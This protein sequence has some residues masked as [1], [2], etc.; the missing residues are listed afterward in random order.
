MNCP[1][2]SEAIHGMAKFCPKCGLPLKDD[3][4]LMGAPAIA[5]D[6]VEGIP[7][8]VLIGG[9]AA[10][11]TV[12]LT[13]GWISASAGGKKPETVRVTLPTNPPG[14]YG[15]S[16]IG[17]PR[18]VGAP[19]WQPAFASYP[20]S[21]PLRPALPPA[22]PSAGPF[23]A[24]VMVAPE[25]PPPVHVLAM[26]PNRPRARESV[27]APVPTKTPLPTQ[28]P[29]MVRAYRYIPPIPPAPMIAGPGAMGGPQVGSPVGVDQAI[30]VGS[31]TGAAD[32]GQ[33]ETAGNSAGYTGPHSS[34]G[35]PG[36]SPGYM[37]RGYT[38]YPV[39]GGYGVAGGMY[40]PYGGYGAPANGGYGVPAYGAGGY[41]GYGALGPYGLRR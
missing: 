37:A 9:A 40:Q 27:S 32:Q 11:L 8:K 29:E 23:A 13:I 3:A 31:E 15:S 26:N 6:G 39:P 7:R 18:N 21:T 30:A 2:C 28:M 33:I 24:P 17:M 38:Q 5:G 19:S 12:A 4:T 36:F 35:H 41:G 10:V 25:P 22:L 14:S 20:S 34:S 1:F 16:M